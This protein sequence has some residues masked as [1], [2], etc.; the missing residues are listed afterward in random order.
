MLLVTTHASH[1]LPIGGEGTFVWEPLS[2]EY[3]FLSSKSNMDKGSNPAAVPYPLTPL[4]FTWK[5]VTRNY[6]RL[7]QAANRRGRNIHLRTLVQ[8]II[9]L[10]DSTAT[11]PVST[12]VLICRVARLS[13]KSNMDNGSNP[14]AV[15]YPLTP[16]VCTWKHATCNHTCFT[17]AI[18]H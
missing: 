15:L 3:F 10:L 7:T 12:C 13:S 17:Q 11:L 9:L 5:H 16:L 8:R 14:T 1:R 6:T 2:R 18:Y 4:V